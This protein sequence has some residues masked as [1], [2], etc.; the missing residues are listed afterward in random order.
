MYGYLQTQITEA[1]SAQIHILIRNFDGMIITH[2]F[3]VC[4]DN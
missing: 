4:L 2:C 3:N 1:T